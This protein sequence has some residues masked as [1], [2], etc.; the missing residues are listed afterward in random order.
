[1]IFLLVLGTTAPGLAQLAPSRIKARYWITPERLAKFETRGMCLVDTSKR[2]PHYTLGAMCSFKFNAL[3]DKGVIKID[4]WRFK[5]PSVNPKDPSSSLINSET[6]NTLQFVLP[7]RKRLSDPTK[8]FKLPYSAWVLSVNSL[9]VKVRPAATD[10]MGLQ[11]DPVVTSSFNLGIN[12]GYSRGFT[13]FTHR[14]QTSWSVA[15]SAG[16]GLGAV[17]LSKEPTYTVIDAK[18]TKGHLLVSPNINLT[19]ARND[20]G[21]VVAYGWDIMAGPHSAVWLY[22]GTHFFGF[23]FSAGLNL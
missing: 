23:G 17:D 6:P 14:S 5:E 2:S 4:P 8:V 21:L 19:F 20:I 22:Q 1:M 9:G 10:T 12:F 18:Q 15:G 13:S 11:Y 16:C 7:P 3:L